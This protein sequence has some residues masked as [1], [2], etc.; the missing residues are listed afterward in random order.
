MNI[1][2]QLT[3]LITLGVPQFSLLKKK[4]KKEKKEKKRN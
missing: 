2:V 1:Q 3:P 4:E